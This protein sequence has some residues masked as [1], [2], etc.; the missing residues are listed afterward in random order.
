MPKKTP[1]TALQLY[2]AK[3]ARLLKLPRPLTKV[4]VTDL[5]AKILYESAAQPVAR[6]IR[7]QGSSSGS[8]FVYSF[9]C[10]RMTSPVPFLKTS[11]L[12]EVRYGFVLLLERRGHLAVFHRGAKGLDD[13]VSKRTRTIERQKLAHLFSATARYQ[14]LSTRRMTISR[15][16][17]RGASYEADDLEM[18]LVPATAARSILQTI[19]MTTPTNGSVGVTP[20]TGRIR[21]SASRNELE[22]L[23]AFADE[24]I[25]AI[26][27]PATSQFLSAFPDAIDL[28]ELPAD[29][30][31]IGVLIDL[32]RVYDLLHDP[33]RPYTIAPPAGVNTVDPLLAGLSQVLTLLPDGERWE[34]ADATGAVHARL[35]RLKSTYS[36]RY[37]F[38]KDYV[39]IDA[40]GV[41]VTLATW[42]H[43]N[44]AFSVAFTSPE[45]FYSGGTLY[46]LAGFEQEVALV[47]RFMSVHQ[48]LDAATSEKG[49]PY[50]RDAAHF[51]PGSI[52]RIVET[53]LAPTD[54]YVW[55]CDLGDEW[56]DYIGVAASRITFYHCKHGTP[57]TGA[58]D[59]QIV[60][61]QA[62]KN[63]AR[64]KF[65]HEEVKQKLAYAR[66]RGHWAD[67]SIPLLARGP[68]DW[69]SLEQHIGEVISDPVATWRVALV[70]TS[71]SLQQFDEAAAMSKPT[72]H[73]IQLVW[74]LSAFVSGCRERDA[75]PTIYCRS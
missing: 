27:A 64:V 47:R 20:G 3:S 23:V 29:V 2:I 65:R 5:F 62:L 26:A 9:L 53:T 11:L 34:A 25:A 35:K 28:D 40:D 56:A 31:P 22:E 7:V 60:V 39:V 30:A 24:V 14:K 17:L 44:S 37:T 8:A 51:A 67:T 49:G 21:V 59:F 68:G 6:E 45:F 71:L 1:P 72:P 73:F 75:Q 50:A 58:S 54:A 38:S 70:V 66:Q 55:C 18:A 46:R 57:T 61:G 74:L 33:E 52:F 32:G 19:R 15:Q 43:R 69:Q 41:H 63:L 48:P 10:F 12:V 4:A 16:E 36:I 42:L 13:A